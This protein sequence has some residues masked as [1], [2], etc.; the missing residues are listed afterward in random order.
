MLPLWGDIFPGEKI[1]TRVHGNEIVR[2]EETESF[3]II[4]PVCGACHRWMNRNFEDRARTLLL[5]MFRLPVGEFMFLRQADL[6]FISRW[7]INTMV[8]HHYSR[9]HAHKPLP[10]AWLDAFR[11][12]P[13]IPTSNVFVWLGGYLGDTPA[14]VIPITSSGKFT[15]IDGTPMDAQRFTIAFG[16]FVAQIMVIFGHSVGDNFGP[17]TGHPRAYYPI[18]PLETLWKKHR[19]KALIKWPPDALM[20]AATV[21]IWGTD[22]IVPQIVFVPPKRRI[23]IPRRF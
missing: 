2:E 16:R 4:T 11:V 12:K 14:V 23:Y 22:P 19:N 7:M 10:K 3:N 21:H 1:L 17:T 6:R 20:D 15:N 13:S 9:P 8:M 18:W 5:P